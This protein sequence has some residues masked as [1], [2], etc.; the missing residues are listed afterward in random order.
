MCEGPTGLIGRKFKKG[1][2]EKGY[3]ADL[4]VLDP[5][6]SFMVDV[7]DIHH[8]HKIT[9]YLNHELY[10]VIEQTWIAGVKVFDKGKMR[11]CE[12]KLLL[13]DSFKTP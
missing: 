5:D 2:I 11:L 9:P 12:G 4:I 3:D 1:R 7:A 10:G 8:Q 6:K 13:A